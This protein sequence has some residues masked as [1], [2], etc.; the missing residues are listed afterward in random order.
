MAATARSRYD[1]RIGA[2]FVAFDRMRGGKVMD[3]GWRK[4]VILAAVLAL[5]ALQ[6]VTADEND[7]VRERALK[8]NQITGSAPLEGQLQQLVR[9]EAGTKKLVEVAAKMAKEKPQP[10]NYTAAFILARASHFVKNFDTAQMFYKI[11]AEDAFKVQSAAKI[12][13]VYDGLIDLFY[14]NKKYDEAIKACREFLEI[15]SPDRTG[16]VNRVKP[17]VMERMIQ[18][19]AKKGKIEEA[20]KLTEELIEADGDGWYFVRLKAEVQ[21]EAGKFEDAAKTYEDTLERIKK[22]K[23]IEEERR[24]RFARGVRYALSGVY[25]ELNKIDKAAEQLQVLLKQNPD[26]PTFMNDLGFVWADHDMK[27]DE[28]EA[29]IRKAIEEDRKQRKKM[30]DLP[31]E[32]DKDNPA[33]LDSLG[34]VLFKKKKFD[35][36]KKHL[37]EA[38]KSKEGEHI[39]ILDHL[40]DVHMALGEKDEAIK[41]WEKALKQENISKRD[42]ERRETVEK[43]L[44][45]AQESK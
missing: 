31:P 29:L 24:D 45:K 2:V 18:S 10:F 1:Y 28:S 3:R 32:E 44:K 5:V 23:D 43:K 12:I 15:D 34:W 19:L 11:A 27:L 7:P 35:E 42:K 37:L 6:P 16:A 40:A 20:L 8:L 4:G 38:A 22:L 36:A 30:D 41:V 26:N 9:D 21:R 17:F 33:Y 13:Q 14:E 39:E 25:V